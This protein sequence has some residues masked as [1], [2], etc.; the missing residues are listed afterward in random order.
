M[1]APGITKDG[2]HAPSSAVQNY[3]M[4]VNYSDQAHLWQPAEANSELLLGS[5]KVQAQ[6]VSIWKVL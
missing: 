2:K 1:S 4:V 5:A 3:Q 6:Q